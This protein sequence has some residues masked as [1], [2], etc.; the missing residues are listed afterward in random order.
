MLLLKILV[1]FILLIVGVLAVGTAREELPRWLHS[2]PWDPPA[3]GPS[4]AEADRAAIYQRVLKANGCRRTDLFSEADVPLDPFR[5]AL[6]AHFSPD[7]EHRIS[8]IRFEE[9]GNV[10][11]VFFSRWRGPLD[12]IQ[13]TYVLSRRRSGRWG[14]DGTEG[15]VVRS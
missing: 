9:E 5:Q 11:K 6:G 14:L 15:W 3:S 2:L 4:N 8:P 1:G 13:A 10:A 7:S 12:G